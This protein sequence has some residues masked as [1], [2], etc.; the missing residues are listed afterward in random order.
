MAVANFP[1]SPLAQVAGA[2]LTTASRETRFRYGAM[3]GR[4]AQ[5]VIVDVLFIG[6]AQRHP[7]QVSQLLAVTLAA[8]AGRRVHRR[9]S[10][11]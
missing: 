10:D 6:V 4:M 8:V 3:S 7:E 1:E 9:R 11:G 5:L 2:V